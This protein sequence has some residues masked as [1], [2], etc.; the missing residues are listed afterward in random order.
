MEEGLA[1]AIITQREY[2]CK[3][4]DNFHLPFLVE[5]AEEPLPVAHRGG[6][7]FFK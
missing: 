7:R 2:K 1:L 5:G 6:D 4:S 3:R